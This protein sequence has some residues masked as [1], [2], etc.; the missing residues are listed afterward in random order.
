MLPG[1]MVEAVCQSLRFQRSG[2][3]GD[4]LGHARIRG[5]TSGDGPPSWSERCYSV[6]TDT[7]LTGSSSGCWLAESLQ[8][9][10]V[11]GTGNAAGALASHSVWATLESSNRL[12]FTGCG[13]WGGGQRERTR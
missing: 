8:V 5:E 6:A 12:K 3:A 2:T 13:V 7:L 9:L 10:S 11:E 1:R 4:C